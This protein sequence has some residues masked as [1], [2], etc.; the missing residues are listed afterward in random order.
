MGKPLIILSQISQSGGLVTPLCLLR[1]A[2]AFQGLNTE[3]RGSVYCTPP[4]S[5][6]EGRH[7]DWTAGFANSRTEHTPLI[8]PLS[9][10]EAYLDVTENLQQID[11]ATEIAEAIRAKIRA[12]TGLTASAGV[13]YNKFLAKMASGQRKPDG[14]FVITPKAG[15]ALSRHF[16]WASFMA[17]GQQPPRR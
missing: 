2:H 11:M 16:P 5:H 8:E 1:A 4:G 9:L 7:E 15:P 14:L 17:S 6:I 13:S 10:D 3:F 12:V